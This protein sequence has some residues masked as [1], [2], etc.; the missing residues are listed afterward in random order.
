MCLYGSNRST[1][2][3]FQTTF[4]EMGNKKNLGSMR[5]NHTEKI[6]KFVRSKIFLGILEVFH[7]YIF[8]SLYNTGKSE[9]LVFV[10]DRKYLY[11]YRKTI[12]VIYLIQHP[13]SSISYLSTNQCWQSGQSYH[14]FSPSVLVIL[15]NQEESE[16]QVWN[17][18]QC[19]VIQIFQCIESLFFFTISASIS[20]RFIV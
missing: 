1:L 2:H 10:K 9:F 13:L 8:P 5:L 17:L 18:Q 4:L 16:R 15:E 3:R 20:K 14:S 6:M 11:R 7:L 19:N 12:H